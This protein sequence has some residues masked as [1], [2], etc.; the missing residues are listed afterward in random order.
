[1]LNP[2][3]TRV[4]ASYIWSL[5]IVSVMLD[6]IAGQYIPLFSRP[7]LSHP[8]ALQESAG[9]KLHPK[10]GCFPMVG[11]Q[12]SFII[13]TLVPG[14]RA[15]LGSRLLEQANYQREHNK[16]KVEQKLILKF[17]HMSAGTCVMANLSLEMYNEATLASIY[18]FI[19]KK[20][21]DVQ[22]RVCLLP[23]LIKTR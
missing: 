17:W 15:D 11:L 9:A 7:K 13:R 10:E 3:R 21:P 16:S 2:Q 8:V 4:L 14:E 6:S 5:Q 18:V 12:H 23:Y 1:M 19:L 22:L 20:T